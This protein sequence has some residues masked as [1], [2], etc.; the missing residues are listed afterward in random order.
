MAGRKQTRKTERFHQIP[1]FSNLAGGEVGRILKITEEVTIPAKTD[2]FKP[3]DPSDA[4][5]IILD[6]RVDIRIPNETGSSTT[7]I[8]TLANRSVFGEMSF[9]GQRPRSAFATTVEETRVNKVRGPDFRAKLDRGDVAA[10]KVIYNFAI[11]ISS[12]L[13][14][15]ENELL[16]VLDGIPPGTKEEKLAELQQFRQTLFQEWSF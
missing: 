12:R 13:R 9:L 15:V 2:V 7:T 16:H 10:Y 8:A 3:G 1:I 14:R 6:G 5:Y 4:F 11:L